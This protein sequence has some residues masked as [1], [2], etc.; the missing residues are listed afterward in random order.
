M[1]RNNEKLLQL[2][3][4]SGSYHR[5]YREDPYL[6]SWLADSEAL[7]VHHDA[8]VEPDATYRC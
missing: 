2:A 5:N 4:F 6:M 3:S 7:D 1:E 8:P